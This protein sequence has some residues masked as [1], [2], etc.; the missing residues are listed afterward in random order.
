MNEEHLATISSWLA[1]VDLAGDE[2]RIEETL[3]SNRASELGFLN[4]LASEED[5]IRVSHH[6]AGHAVVAHMLGRVVHVC[7]VRPDGSG[8]VRHSLAFTPSPDPTFVTVSEAMG[9]IVTLIA[10]AA[11]E[12]V[13]GWFSLG[14]GYSVKR[15]YDFLLARQRIEHLKERVPSWNLSTETFAKL[16][17]CMVISNWRAICNVAFSLKHNGNVDGSEIAALCERAN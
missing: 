3:Q 5:M 2:E 4:E 7:K 11:S 1:R 12:L 13:S 6:E 8:L 17:Y 10:G 16:T 9:E 15:S 14:R